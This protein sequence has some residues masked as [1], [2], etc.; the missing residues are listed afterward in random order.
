[1]TT[2]TSQLPLFEV[3]EGK[4]KYQV[5]LTPGRGDW[6][7]NEALKASRK[8]PKPKYSGHKVWYTHGRVGYNTHPAPFRCAGRH[9]SSR[10]PYCCWAMAWQHWYESQGLEVPEIKDWD[11]PDVVQMVDGGLQQG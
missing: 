11:H 6:Y 2:S 3:Q 4:Y 7:A 10:R 5:R 8:A 1:M 9:N